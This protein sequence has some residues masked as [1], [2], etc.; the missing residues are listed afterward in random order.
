MLNIELPN[1]MTFIARSAEDPMR[2]GIDIL[3]RL[4]SGIED[5]LCFAEYDSE[6]TDKIRICAFADGEDE[7]AYNAGFHVLPDDE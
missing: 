7:P 4:P 1:G 3:L 2:P 5:L 6:N